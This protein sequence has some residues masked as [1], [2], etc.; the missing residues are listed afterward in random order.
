MSKP[1]SVVKF[2]RKEVKSRGLPRWVKSRRIGILVSL[3]APRWYTWT[4]QQVQHKAFSM[5]TDNFSFCCNMLGTLNLVRL[6]AVVVF[7]AING[8]VFNA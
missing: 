3:V 7:F 8:Y 2:E 5:H 1:E 4:N 6:P